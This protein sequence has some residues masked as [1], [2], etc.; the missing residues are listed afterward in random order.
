MRGTDRNPA[1]RASAALLCLA[2]ALAALPSSLARE[3]GEVSRAGAK[4]GQAAAPTKR[5]R[6][7][8]E[9]W[10][11]TPSEVRVKRGTHVVLEL[12]SGDA[13][14]AFELKEYGIKVTVPQGEVVRA[15]FDATRVGTFPWRCSRPCGDGCA[16]LRGK[17]IVEE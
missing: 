10:A 14:R 6:I 15:E 9:K 3:G 7:D 12:T 8:A 11:W 4:A 2:V 5:V 16:K 13:S 17:L 1:G